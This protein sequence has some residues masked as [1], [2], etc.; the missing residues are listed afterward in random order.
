VLG[1][2]LTPDQLSHLIRGARALFQQP[3]DH[4]GQAGAPQ[5]RVTV[6]GLADQPPVAVGEIDREAKFFSC[7]AP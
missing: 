1:G 5:P 4:L 2:A 3:D 7:V 6:L